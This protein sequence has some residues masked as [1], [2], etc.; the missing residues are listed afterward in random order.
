MGTWLG[1]CVTVVA[2]KNIR[3]T[4]L[5]VIAMAI[6]RFMLYDLYALCAA[7]AHKTHHARSRLSY[8]L[9]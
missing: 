3:V 2:K 6:N 8:W 7:K 5:M 1:S 4:M 9:G